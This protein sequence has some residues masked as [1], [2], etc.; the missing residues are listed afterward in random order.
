MPPSPPVHL[1]ADETSP[2][3]ILALDSGSPTVSV[4]LARDGQVLFEDTVEIGR[5]SQRLLPMIDAALAEAGVSA[6]DLAG[7]V[8]LA[9]P[10]SFTGLRVGLATALGLHQ[11]LAVPATAVPTLTTLARVAPTDPDPVASEAGDG[12]RVLALVDVLRDEWACQEFRCNGGPPRPLGGAER[13]SV[14]ELASRLAPRADD[15]AWLV[16][17]GVSALEGRL[18]E[19]LAAGRIRLH[20]P[21]GLAAAAARAATLA[22]PDWDPDSLTSPLYFRPPAVTLPRR[23]SAKS[24]AGGESAKLGSEGPG[25]VA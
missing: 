12:Q 18:D 13:L 16:G 2:R 24:S 6:A 25:A 9:G 22:P 23:R 15:P 21:T 19:A 3:V 14:A 8:A 4:A 1:T 5:S 17:F 7:I 20:E 11:A 10:G